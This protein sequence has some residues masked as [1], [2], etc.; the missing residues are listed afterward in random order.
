MVWLYWIVEGGYGNLVMED[1]YG[2]WVMEGGYGDILLNELLFMSM[3]QFGLMDWLK[4]WM[5]PNLILED[6]VWICMACEYNW[7]IRGL[8]WHPLWCN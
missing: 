7:S 1:G 6:V 8:K 5:N 3:A 4:G 2:N